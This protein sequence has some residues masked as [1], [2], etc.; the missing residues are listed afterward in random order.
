MALLAF[1]REN[2][3]VAALIALMVAGLVVSFGALM[4]LRR[5]RRQPAGGPASEAPNE[6]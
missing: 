4:L 6:A 3:I 1:D 2:M 5:E